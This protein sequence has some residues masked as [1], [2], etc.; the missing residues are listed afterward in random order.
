MK[1]KD[2]LEDKGLSAP[3]IAKKLGI[4]RSYFNQIIN[5]RRIPSIHLARKIESLCDGRVKA[6]EILKL[7]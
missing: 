2:Y 1:L 4:T 3:K 6:T 5:E 7:K